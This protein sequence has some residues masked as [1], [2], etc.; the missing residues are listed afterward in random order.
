MDGLQWLCPA[1][2]ENVSLLTFG[3]PS[4]YYMGLADLLGIADL[5]CR[6]VE[7]TK[8]LKDKL[9]AMLGGQ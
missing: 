9:R 1:R 4:S 6:K 8:W 5:D 2:D 7:S 3:T